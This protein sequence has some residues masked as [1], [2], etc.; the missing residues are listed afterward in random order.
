M[1]K[2]LLQQPNKVNPKVPRILVDSTGRRTDTTSS[3]ATATNWDCPS[4]TSTS[5]SPSSTASLDWCQASSL[6]LLV[7]L[8]L[9]GFSSLLVSNA[10]IGAI[11]IDNL[12]NVFSPS[13]VEVVLERNGSFGR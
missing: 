4:S 11:G 7:L 5:A 10:K 8:A 1:L 12:E 13:W 3:T 2:R 9:S 6:A